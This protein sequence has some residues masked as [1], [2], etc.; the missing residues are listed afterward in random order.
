LAARAL[1]ASTVISSGSKSDSIA[2]AKKFGANHV[3]NYR[4][5]DT[6]AKVNEFTDGKGVDL[7][8]DAAYSE[9]GFAESAKTVKAGGKWVVL[10]VGPDKTSRT[11]Q[12]DS[13]VD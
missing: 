10:G 12:T 11:A 7:V 2:L 6:A 4:T 1:E 5:E 3:F 9:A 8:F 13:P